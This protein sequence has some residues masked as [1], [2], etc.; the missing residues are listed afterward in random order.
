MKIGYARVSSPDQKLDRQINLLKEVHVMK[1]FSEKV[2][3]KNVQ[4]KALQELLSFIHAGDEVYVTSLDRLGRNS[5]ELTAVIE[6]IR[7]KKAVL[8][9]LDLPS[10]DGIK[11]K[12]LQALLTNLV[13]EIQKYIAENE[14]KMIRERQRQGI[15]LAKQKGVYKGRQPVYSPYTK[16]RQNRLIYQKIVK[17]LKCYH[18]NGHINITD[19]AIKTGVSRN[20][21]YRINKQIYCNT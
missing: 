9:I 19:I 10:F 13:L 1:I 2:S 14:R 12:N 4:R 8:N 18:E 17:L 11:D 15:E 16:N 21:V 3:G 20:T 5:T 7:Y 6:I